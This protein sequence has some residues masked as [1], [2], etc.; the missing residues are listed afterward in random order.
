MPQ[1]PRT[2]RHNAQRG[3]EAC[4]GRNAFA[5]STRHSASPVSVAVSAVAVGTSIGRPEQHRKMSDSV[6]NVHELFRWPWNGR[7]LLRF[8][9]LGVHSARWPKSNGNRYVYQVFGFRNMSHA[10]Y[11]VN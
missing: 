5:V 1:Y 6:R 9:L 7:L 4:T 10:L 8:P 11:S 3:S 2:V